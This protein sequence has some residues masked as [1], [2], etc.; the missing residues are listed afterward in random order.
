[1]IG[2]EFD[3][4]G[5]KPI[6]RDQEASITPNQDAAGSPFSIPLR[7]RGEVIGTLDVWS[8]ES[9]LSDADVYLLATIS[10]RI[11][12]ILE[13]TRLLQEAQRLAWREQQ[14]NTIATQVRNSINLET[15]LQNTVRELGK[16]LG[17]A[18]A[19]IQV[20]GDLPLPESDQARQS[21]QVPGVMEPTHLEPGKIENAA[22]PPADQSQPPGSNGRSPSSPA[23]TRQGESEA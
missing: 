22:E 13:S 12:Q 1:V 10:N 20:G 5:A 17:V 11:S 7:V 14:V 4:V 21:N 6:L 18:R 16:S 23:A 2:Y 19:F 9:D 3:G 15:I 8:Q